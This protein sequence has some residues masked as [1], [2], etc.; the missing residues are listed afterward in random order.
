MFVNPAKEFTVEG[1][2]PGLFRPRALFFRQVVDGADRRRLGV[3][4]VEFEDAPIVLNFCP[5][6]EGENPFFSA[7]FL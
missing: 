3:F 4:G 5:F 7:L 6:E 2:R 1:R